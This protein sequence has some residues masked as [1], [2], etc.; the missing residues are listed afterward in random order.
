MN[1]GRRAGARTKLAVV[2]VIVLV[3]YLFVVRFL[4]ESPRKAVQVERKAIEAPSDKELELSG[5]KVEHW[6][7]AKEYFCNPDIRVAREYQIDLSKKL[8]STNRL[9]SRL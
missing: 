8:W 6:S 5:V 4:V 1:R 2:V 7:R 9:V 3:A